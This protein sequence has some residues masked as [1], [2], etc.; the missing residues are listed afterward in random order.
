MPY[1]NAGDSTTFLNIGNVG[2]YLRVSEGGTSP[3]W[4]TLSYSDIAET[5]TIGSGIL[6]LGVSGSGLTGSA[7]FD[8]N[9][10]GTST[11]T[12]SSNATD[13]NTP[14]TIVSRDGSGNFSAGTITADL[15]GTASTAT[16]AT[17][18][19]IS[20]NSSTDTSTYLVIVGNNATG[21]QAPMIDPG[22]SYNANTNILTTTQ[23]VGE[24]VSLVTATS[25]TSIGINYNAD[26]TFSVISSGILLLGIHGDSTTAPFRVLP[27]GTITNGIWSGTTIAANK[28][29]TGQTSYAV[30][31]LLYANTTSTLA[32]LA[33]VAT[34]NVLLAG[35][36]NTAP[37][38]GKV[39]L[40]THVSG[41]LAVGNGGTGAT[42]LTGVV[43]GNGA[44]AF[45]ATSSTTPYA[46]LRVN[47]AGNAY[48]FSTVIDGGTP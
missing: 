18:I 1:Q 8:A 33:D 4:H 37:S 13:Q 22:L 2:Q 11:F 40:T 44:S 32:K 3:E 24:K 43:I 29:G 16:S 36:V 15:T 27:N 31:D 45:T 34:G 47:D 38:W 48:E 20:S 28:G 17:N 6:T 35:G 21:D 41:T 46:L 12:V 9:Q 26:Q 30:G 14:S 5:P 23:Y 7:S 19:N 25:D 10:T 39:G 42:T